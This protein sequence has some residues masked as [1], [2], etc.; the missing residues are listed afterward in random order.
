[1]IDTTGKSKLKITDELRR[2]IQAENK[3]TDQEKCK[4]TA[5]VVKPQ[6]EVTNPNARVREG[7]DELT[8]R[9]EEKGKALASH[10]AKE[11]NCDKW[12][13]PPADEDW[14]VLCQVMLWKQT[15]G[16]GCDTRRDLNRELN[17]KGVGEQMAQ[18]RWL[19]P[20]GWSKEWYDSTT[21]KDENGVLGS[22]LARPGQSLGGGCEEGKRRLLVFGLSRF[23]VSL[24]VKEV[25]PSPPLSGHRWTWHWQTFNPPRNWGC[26]VLNLIEKDEFAGVVALD[27]FG[28]WWQFSECLPTMEGR[29]SKVW[30]SDEM[31]K[32]H[33]EC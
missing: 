24:I 32:R 4:E 26:A 12:A 30:V 16:T 17:V 23:L 29:Q 27:N 3:E 11:I 5:R 25:S 2:F 15:N 1:M 8:L 6:F 33:N 14:H 19:K 31:E 21:K 9:A 20:R 7:A 10:N 13:P 18:G 28:L 22:A